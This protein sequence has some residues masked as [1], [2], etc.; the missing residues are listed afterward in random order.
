MADDGKFLVLVDGTNGWV[1]NM[2]TP[3]GLN[4]IT[5]GNFT[6]SPK[7]VNVAYFVLNSRGP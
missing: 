2:I 6:T 5:D 7:T 4:K 1:Y 3:A